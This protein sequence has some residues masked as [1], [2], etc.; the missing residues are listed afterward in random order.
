MQGRSGPACH[1]RAR[2]EMQRINGGQLAGSDGGTARRP[3]PLHLFSRRRIEVIELTQILPG[4]M[5]LCDKV[6]CAGR[7][8]EKC[9]GVR[10]VLMRLL[11]L[12]DSTRNRLVNIAL[13]LSVA[14]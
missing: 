8:L 6:P 10:E 5:G 1:F 12:I 14:E 4:D 3:N 2:L 9:A 13:S 11:N 7:L